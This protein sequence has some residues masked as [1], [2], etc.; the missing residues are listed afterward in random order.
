MMLNKRRWFVMAQVEIWDFLKNQRMKGN[1]KFFSA[2]EVVRA[3]RLNGSDGLQNVRKQLN[4]LVLYDFMEVHSRLDDRGLWPRWRK[5]Y[6]VKMLVLKRLYGK[7]VGR[8]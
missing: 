5:K 8:R 3:L 2:E 4:K 6:R 7:K 1:D